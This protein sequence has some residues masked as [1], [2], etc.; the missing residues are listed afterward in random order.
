M[1][2]HCKLIKRRWKMGVGRW[3]ILLSAISYLQSAAAQ[4]GSIF[5][6]ENHNGHK[7]FGLPTPTAGNEAATKAYADS[8]GGGGGGGVP[9]TRTLTIGGTAHDLSA[10]R[11]WTAPEILD[12]ISS[13]WGAILFRGVSNWIA[14]S[15]GTAGDVLTTHGAGAS[16]TWVTPT[17]GGNLS[18]TGSPLDNQVAVFTDATHVEGNSNL[19]FDSS[20]NILSTGIVSPLTGFRINGAAANRRILIGN[21]TNFVQSTETYAVPGTSGNVMLSDGTNWTS[22][23]QN[24]SGL[25]G[26]WTLAQGPSTTASKL[27]GR[28]DA[29]AGI[30]QEITLGTNLAM[31]GT[32]LNATGGSV[33]APLTLTITDA[34]TTTPVDPLTLTHTSSGTPA[35]GFGTGVLFTG[36]SN[37]NADRPL[38]EILSYWSVATD[39]SRKSIMVLRPADSTGVIGGGVYIFSDNSISVNDATD[40]GAG[41]LNLASGG[42]LKIGGTATAGAI[43]QGNSGSYSPSTAL[44]PV[45][46]GTSG[47]VVCSGGTNYQVSGP[48]FPTSAAGG[49][50]TVIQSN[51]TNWLSSTPT[52]P[53]TAGAVGYTIRSDATNLASY[54]AQLVNSSTASQSPTTSDVYLTGSNIV[55][56]AGDFKAKGQYKCVFDMTKSTGTGAIVITL[57]VGTAGTTAD[58]AIQTYTFGAGT[59]VADFG[60]FEVIATWR[61]VGSGTSAVM[62]GMCRGT[63]QLA[64]TGLF[65]N[66]AGWMVL[67]SP[68]PSSGFNSSSATNIGISFN[69]STAFAGTTQLVQAQLQQ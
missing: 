31:S 47:K 68:S 39:A 20:T 11:T 2:L 13:T 51:G 41:I 24:F 32:T 48:T 16:P 57:R 62:Q 43:L 25:A 19:S 7:I 30:P 14:L 12:Q 9:T 22:A 8:V 36:K 46:P 17:A 52:W 21:A 15:P 34:T 23:Q 44:W 29:S 60:L 64:T 35:T 6:D 65:N 63:H 28:T 27:L 18:T 45:S 56:T 50:G 38:G 5:V 40:Y 26:N 3:A 54:P 4:T 59:S 1:D 42:A 67:G 58:A 37:G 10:D 69:G 49:A 66:A 33:T 61:T 53:T 55:V